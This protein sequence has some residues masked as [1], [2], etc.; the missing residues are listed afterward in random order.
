MKKLYQTN[1]HDP[2]LT[3]RLLMVLILISSSPLIAQ[4]LNGKLAYSHVILH[5][6]EMVVHN[7]TSE[8][9]SPS[10]I[11]ATDHLTNPLGKYYL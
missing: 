5:K 4:K 7:P 6:N 9:I 3:I 11:T 1:A 8:F 2:R 10:V